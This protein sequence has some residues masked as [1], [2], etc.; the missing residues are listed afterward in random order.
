MS[1][2]AGTVTF[3]GPA[4]L[5]PADYSASGDAAGAAASVGGATLAA[6]AEPARMAQVWGPEAE[7]QA[8][9]VTVQELD[10]EQQSLVDLF[11]DQ[12]DRLP[13]L[14]RPQSPPL[15]H[16]SCLGAGVPPP[17]AAAVA[18]GTGTRVRVR[19][20]GQQ[21]YS[22]AVAGFDAASGHHTIRYDDGDLRAHDMRRKKFELLLPAAPDQAAAARAAKV[23][24]LAEL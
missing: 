9:T 13:P 24:P 12:L 2:N 5:F 15:A 8:R 23:A 22:G 1:A 10:E 7:P 20:Q 6:L 19:W 14:R 17:T 16:R 11:S 4:S 18:L 3:E 21:W